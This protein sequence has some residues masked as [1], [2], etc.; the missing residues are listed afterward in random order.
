M[1]CPGYRSAPSGKIVT[2]VLPG[3]RRRAMLRAAAAATPE[4]PPARRP[5]SRAR[6]RQVSKASASVI[7]TTSSICAAV[8]DLGKERKADA[9][10]RVRP[11]FSA[12]EDRALRLG[13]D[14]QEV[15]GAF[16][17][18]TRDAHE[19]PGRPDAGDE[20]V[21]RAAE[22]LTD[23]GPRRLVVR[24]GVDGV[25]EL[26]RQV[27]AG[28]PGRDLPGAFDRPAHEVRGRGPDDRRAQGLHQL[29][30]DVAVPLRHHDRR[31]GS[32]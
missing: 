7:V 13:G 9:L 28:R 15:R 2:T 32:P 12:S 23:L 20:G 1:P 22:D 31:S 25:G 18:V 10:D 11:L 29:R 6:R 24:A 21:H 19:G 5:S 8:E 4:E 26:V 17:E 27:G 3:P 30:L 14:A 16:A